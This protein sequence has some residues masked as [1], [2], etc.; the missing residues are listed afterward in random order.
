MVIGLPISWKVLGKP[1]VADLCHTL[2]LLRRKGAEF[3]PDN[4]AMI[5]YFLSGQA[6]SPELNAF[7]FEED[8]R[9]LVRSI[10][11]LW[12]PPA[13]QHELLAL[14]TNNN[15]SISENIEED[16]IRYECPICL[17]NIN[18][19]KR[20]KAVTLYCGH[21]FCWKC[22]Y[23][24]GHAD[25]ISNSPKLCPLC[26]K[27][28]CR[29]VCS[30]PKSEVGD[31]MYGNNRENQHKWGSKLLTDEQVKIECA[32]RKISTLNLN[33]DSLRDNLNLFDVKTQHIAL[34]LGASKSI[35]TNTSGFIAP[36]YGRVAIPITLKGVPIL[37]YVSSKSP[38]TVASKVF[39]ETFGLRR[40]NLA[41]KK[42][43]NFDGSKLKSKDITA[44]DE[45]ELVVGDICIKINSA[46]EASAS[47]DFMGLQLGWDF[48][49]SLAYW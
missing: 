21:T 10:M 7:A 46:I 9:T 1:N 44:L 26:R 23:D 4:L 28:L 32:A 40:K 35:M 36:K 11:G 6:I 30:R 48:F 18:D 45:F 20:K 17:E 14:K 13:I 31:L 5:G 3:S 16:G 37:A 47:H 42:F 33:D 22:I 19:E 41:S 2:I 29:E 43:R 15:L 49:C 25:N 34:N 12:L 8:M 27:L 38:F 39:V 24:Y